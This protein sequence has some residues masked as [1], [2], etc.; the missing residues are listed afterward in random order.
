VRV[1]RNVSDRNS[2][3]HLHRKRPYPRVRHGPIRG[4]PEETGCGD[5]TGCG[6][7][8]AAF[9]GAGA[10]AF[11]APHPIPTF[12]LARRSSHQTQFQI[13]AGTSC[14]W[15]PSTHPLHSNRTRLAFRI[16]DRDLNPLSPWCSIAT[17]ALPSHYLRNPPS[18]PHGV[19]RQATEARLKARCASYMYIS[20]VPPPSFTARCRVGGLHLPKHNGV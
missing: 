16:H 1:D 5:R 10:S 7:G 18:A 12:L 6:G 20:V 19:A 4:K 9:L 8:E 17:R 14:R 15:H 13:T 3:A 2:S 11:D